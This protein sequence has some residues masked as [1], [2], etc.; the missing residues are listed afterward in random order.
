MEGGGDPKFKNGGKKK[1]EK[2]MESSLWSSICCSCHP[3]FVF[4]FL[5]LQ[6][7]VSYSIAPEPERKGCPDAK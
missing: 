3:L 1:R 5:T 6:S 4:L 2:R 7:S